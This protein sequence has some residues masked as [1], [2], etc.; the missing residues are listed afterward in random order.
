MMGTV[1]QPESLGS[2]GGASAN[3]FE[4]EA[5]VVLTTL[6]SAVNSVLAPLAVRRPVEL[7]RLLKIDGTLS[8]QI[9]KVAGESSV[10]AAGSSVPSRVS[11]EKFSTAAA[12]AGVPEAKVDSLRAAYDAFE[13]LVEKHAGDRTS[14]NSLV[15]SASGMS[16]DWL[17]ADL[18]HRR[19]AFRSLS[20]AMGAQAKT[21]FMCTVISEHE[22]FSVSGLLG[23]RMFR[24]HAR[25]RVHGTRIEYG[26]DDNG[27]IPHEPLGLSDKCGGYLVEQFSSRPI[28]AL[29]T[30]R[31][32]FP[33]GYWV[34]TSL[35]K[36]EVGNTGVSDLL[37]GEIQ[38]PTSVL[39]RLQL[40]SVLPT[41][42]ITMEVLVEPG[43]MQRAKPGAIPTGLVFLGD[44]QAID[45]GSDLI[46]LEG[47]GVLERLG[48]GAAALA[49][50]DVPSYPEIIEAAA[51]HV[52][53]DISKYE[54]WRLRVEFPLYRSTLRLVWR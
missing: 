16:D 17:A 37:F 29:E 7:Q 44:D 53:R 42:L 39:S 47:N 31:G 50:P 24:S 15:T 27:V 38:R 26:V 11:I 18:Q 40:I 46:P 35:V 33:G 13:K 1:V 32:E 3:R 6:K 25:L 43:L 19:N 54:V 34:E 51:K 22:F 12:A 28:P 36:P 23:L 45:R 49:G 9:L 4:S 20:H 14:F 10:L 8:W 41:E 52:G 21:R 30:Q 5:T 48:L 2:F